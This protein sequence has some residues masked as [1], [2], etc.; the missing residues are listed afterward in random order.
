M[1]FPRGNTKH[2]LPSVCN[3]HAVEGASLEDSAGTVDSA[4]C[5]K[6]VE[7]DLIRTDSD[8]IAVL[9]MKNL[10]E[11]RPG[12]AVVFVR[13]TPFRQ[14]KEFR[15]WDGPERRAD[16]GCVYSGDDAEEENAPNNE[17]L[18]RVV[19]HGYHFA[20]LDS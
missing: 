2:I 15:A 1:I 18:N 13:E 14:S 7:R 3:E 9:L 16:E 11:C 5:R 17:G 4:Q 8:S 10:H 12:T 6:A 20:G 19:V